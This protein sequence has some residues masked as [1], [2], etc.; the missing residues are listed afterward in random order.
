MLT[1]SEGLHYGSGADMLTVS[2][3]LH[4]GSG[5]DLVTA[6]DHDTAATRPPVVYGPTRRA[7]GGPARACPVGEYR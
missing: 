3:G 1:V 5:A 7:P 4:Y 2:E 6:S